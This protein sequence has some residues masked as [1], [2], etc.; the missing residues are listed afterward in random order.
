MI[1]AGGRIT[2]HVYKKYIQLLS[3]TKI[4]YSRT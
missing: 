3:E 4:T 1:S 2:R